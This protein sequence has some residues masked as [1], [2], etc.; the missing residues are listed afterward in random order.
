MELKTNENRFENTL[1]FNKIKVLA[2]L[3]VVIIH[4]CATFFYNNPTLSKIWIVSTFYNCLARTAVPLFVMISG[5]IYLNE[6][7]QITLKHLYKTIARFVIIFFFWDLLF[8]FSDYFLV[9]NSKFDLKTILNILTSL[10]KYKYHLWYLLD[11]II[12]LALV[13]ILRLVCKKENR[14][15]IKYLLLLFL[16]FNS[17]LTTFGY[18]SSLVSG[19]GTAIVILKNI[20]SVLNLFNIHQ[21]SSLII[22]FIT[23]WYFS[24]FN[25]EN[26]IKTISIVKWLIGIFVP[27]ITV[28]ICVFLE[29]KKCFD[30][31]AH[32][33]YLPN[34]ILAICIFLTFRY[35]KKANNQSKV[36]EKINNSSLF[37]YL[38]HPLFIDIINKYLIT[39]IIAVCNSFW[40]ILIIPAY[41]LIVYLLSWLLSTIINLIPKKIRKWIC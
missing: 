38:V 4:V 39:N 2:S 29:N 37:I 19:K 18:L 36:V 14:K 32:Y 5:A 28:T 26:H 33:Y 17:F 1:Y 41:V 12:L 30:L 16:F 21:L 10:T 34:Y 31:I 8:L 24:T 27:I 25:F 9:N 11:Y 20:V 22:L 40:I 7:K 15:Q 23:G 35:S 13:P 3:F 6:N